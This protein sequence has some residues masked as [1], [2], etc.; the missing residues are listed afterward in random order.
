MTTEALLNFIRSHYPNVTD[1]EIEFAVANADGLT[2]LVGVL[3]RLAEMEEDE[4][5]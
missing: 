1:Y 3:G 4:A 2:S 5:A